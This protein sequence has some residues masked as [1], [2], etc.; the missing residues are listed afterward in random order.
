MMMTEDQNIVFCFDP[1]GAASYGNVRPSAG[2][3]VSIAA[4]RFPFLAFDFM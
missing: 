4:D 1:T 2:L 3:F